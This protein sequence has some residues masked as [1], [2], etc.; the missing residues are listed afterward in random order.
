MATP[1]L[2]NV[3]NTKW[4][5]VNEFDVVINLANKDKLT[6]DHSRLGNVWDNLNFY[7]TSVN[8]PD[9]T[10]SPIDTY[11]GNE[12][13]LEAGREEIQ[14]VTITFRD[15]DNFT[16]YNNVR[17]WLVATKDWYTNEK[18]LQLSI[19]QDNQGIYEATECY[20]ESISNIS[21]SRENAS[22]IGI[23]SATFKVKPDSVKV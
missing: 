1:F 18:Q 14:R 4:T 2:Q 7:I 3:Y 11:Y 8:T 12:W 16:I 23:F 13:A 5:N 20:L 19:K 9:I 22:Q 21:F 6:G 15:F 17:A 10:Q